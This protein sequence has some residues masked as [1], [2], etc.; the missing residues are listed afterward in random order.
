MP[1]A[2]KLRIRVH[3]TDRIIKQ[4]VIQSF[5][6]IKL[7]DIL[8]SLNDALFTVQKLKFKIIKYLKIFVSQVEKTKIYL[9]IK[10]KLKKL[11]HIQKNMCTTIEF[12]TRN[13]VT[14]SILDQN[15]LYH[16]SCY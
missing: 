5:A 8:N 7:P 11:W 10:K 15:M 16:L 4:C 14:N 6:L 12:Q 1:C 3:T 9:V 13:V 2:F